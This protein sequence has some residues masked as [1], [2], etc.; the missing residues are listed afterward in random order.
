MVHDSTCSNARDIWNYYKLSG[1]FI[2]ALILLEF[3]SVGS[4]S[5]LMKRKGSFRFYI[6]A[7]ETEY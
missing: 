4:I 1:R 3:S 7:F 6:M 2:R 5:I